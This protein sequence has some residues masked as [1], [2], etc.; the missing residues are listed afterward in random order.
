MRAPDRLPLEM[1]RRLKQQQAR[2]EKARTALVRDLAGQSLTQ[3]ALI[4]ARTWD[5]LGP[6]GIVALIG[7]NRELAH[8]RLP[9]SSAI[10][11]AGPPSGGLVA[12]LKKRLAHWRAVRPLPV[13]AVAALLRS[14]L[15]GILLTA[16]ALPARELGIHLGW[17]DR[18]ASCPR[19]D[20]WGGSCAYTTRSNS[21]TLERIAAAVGRPLADLA[22]AN[23]KTPLRSALPRGAQVAIP[24]RPLINT[25]R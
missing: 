21:L 5:R 18:P 14:S 3:L 12:K 11:K 10:P 13:V 1:R 24:T 22:A 9:P 4:P 6:K 25:A 23:P 19:L 2:A 7:A 17:L 8:L 15:V 20:H 16:A